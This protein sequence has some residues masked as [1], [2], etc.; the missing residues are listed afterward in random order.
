MIGDRLRY[1]RGETPRDVVCKACGISLSALTM[2]ELGERLPRD[3]VKVKLAA[4]YRNTVQAIFLLLFTRYS[5]LVVVA[6]QP[7]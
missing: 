1:L 5:S 7:E 2:Y 6:L 3:E 4:Y